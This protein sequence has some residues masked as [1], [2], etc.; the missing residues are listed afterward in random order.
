[1]ENPFADAG[2]RVAPRLRHVPRSAN[3]E[4]RVVD[5]PREIPRSD[6]LA[7]LTEQAEYGSWELARSVV[8]EGGARRVW[9]KRRRIRVVRTDAA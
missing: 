5:I 6:A 9:L 4:W 2:H 8:F 1:M 7:L 3:F